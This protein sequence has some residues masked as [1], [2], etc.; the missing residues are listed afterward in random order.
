[1]V[2][3]IIAFA[4]WKLGLVETVNVRIAVMAVQS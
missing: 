4:G 2:F 3:G 1:M